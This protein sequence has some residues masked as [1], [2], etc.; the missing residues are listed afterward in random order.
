[1]SQ[2]TLSYAHGWLVKR[3]TD[4]ATVPVETYVH[5]RVLLTPDY[6]YEDAA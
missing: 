6:R 2:R 3:P 4:P 1:M 5:G